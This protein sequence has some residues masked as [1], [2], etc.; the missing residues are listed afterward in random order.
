[1]ERRLLEM[2]VMDADELKALDAG[3]MSRIQESVEFAKQSPDPD[4]EDALKDIF[5]E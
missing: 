3:I 1:M 4:P 2:G 5:S